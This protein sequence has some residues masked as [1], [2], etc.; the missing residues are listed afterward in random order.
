VGTRKT[1]K[2][3][4]LDQ[5]QVESISRALSDPRRFQILKRIAA[6]PCTAC[7]D[8]RSAFSITAATLSHH[9]RELESC[10]LVNIYRRGKFV[11][12]VFVRSTWKAYLRALKEI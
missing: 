11:D 7:M 3:A 12:A 4:P 8:M 5:R 2:A 9:L 10:G 6:Q 1:A